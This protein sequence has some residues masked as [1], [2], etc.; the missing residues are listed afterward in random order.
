M[1]HIEDDF[2]SDALVDFSGFC[3]TLGGLSSSFSL[4]EFVDYCAILEGMV[5]HDRLIV[6][7]NSYGIEKWNELLDPLEKA[8]VIHKYG[9]STKIFSPGEPPGQVRSEVDF[10]VESMNRR[11]KRNKIARSTHTDSWYEA[12]RLLGAE[13]QLGCTSLSLIRQGPY[14]EKYSQA[15]PQ[16]T[17]TNLLAKYRD[18]SDALLEIR[19]QNRLL[20]DQF[21]LV[22]IPPIPLLAFKRSKSFDEILVRTLEIRED[23]RKLRE[24][25]RL[26]RADLHDETIPPVKKKMII[27]SW[28]KS[29]KT[30]GKYYEQ[31]SFVE[32]GNRAL[33]VP[34]LNK[35]IDDIGIDSVKL[36]SILK[37]LLSA[38][39]KLYYSWRVRILHDIARKYLQAPDSELNHEIY[40]LFGTTVEAQD[41]TELHNWLSGTK[42]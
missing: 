21:I 31:S 23:F 20:Y 15:R 1:E 40:K 7:G 24:S 3:K 38:S 6:I 17:V 18:L 29:W 42:V 13:K 10:N 5:L 22:P 25:L 37:L 4:L 27:N 8:G 41:L 19:K 2:Y 11:Y 16:H 36:T 32:I 33:D 14:Y 35:A 9:K 34:D 26:L 30:L 12:G 28:Q 39:S